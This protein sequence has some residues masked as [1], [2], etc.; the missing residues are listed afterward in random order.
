MP[1]SWN[2]IKNLLELSKV[3]SPF[4][5]VGKVISHVLKKLALMTI[6]KIFS[7]LL[8]I[9]QT[10]PMGQP[11]LMLGYVH[12]ILFEWML[13]F[14]CAPNLVAFVCLNAFQLTHMNLPFFS[15]P[16]SQLFIGKIYRE[17][18]IL[19]LL[20]HF[21]V[22]FF[23]NIGKHAWNRLQCNCV[24]GLL[25]SFIDLVNAIVYGEIEYF[26]SELLVW[27]NHSLMQG[28]Y[29]DAMKF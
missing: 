21:L 24:F 10:S 25:T 3:G 22:L 26:A 2:V 9:F 13:L 5:F 7:I 29:F 16:L 15:P 20:T 11:C 19:E 8:Q 23:V 4:V 6:T 28:C 1:C 12:P 14:P 27:C 18:Q 17:L